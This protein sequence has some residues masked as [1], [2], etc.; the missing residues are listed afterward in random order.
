MC[1]ILTY[2]AAPSDRIV[3]LV[4]SGLASQHGRGIDGAGYILIP[5]WRAD[6]PIVRRFLSPFHALP[7]L[8][9]D[10]EEQADRDGLCSIAFHHRM[11]TSTSNV[12]HCNH[13]IASD[14]SFL[15]HN[16]I[17]FNS[18]ELK[19][20][21]EKEGIMYTTMD[22][23]RF[24]DSE[25]LAHDVTL[26][27]R[28]PKENKR[29][30][31]YKFK[32]QGSFAFVRYE[33]ATRTLMYARNNMNPLLF[34]SLENGTM[35]LCSE[36]DTALLP[37]KEWKNLPAKVLFMQN[38]ETLDLRTATFT[39]KEYSFPKAKTGMPPYTYSHGQHHGGRPYAFD[40]WDDFDSPLVK[41]AEQSAMVFQDDTYIP[42]KYRLTDAELRELGIDPKTI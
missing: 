7:Q 24:N 17:I 18:S 36:S 2:I 39:H 32:S 42:T 26:A 4:A 27:L 20:R 21:H 9:K 19:P 30:T 23:T 11:P 40:D 38:L 10:I 15:I 35:A 5:H 41:S 8:Q 31:S 6:K 13:P 25:A 29:G 34:A 14:G 3:P 16:G 12:E 33:P 37:H 28:K 22:G 1:G